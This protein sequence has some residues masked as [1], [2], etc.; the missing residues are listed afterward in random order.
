MA[1]ASL[2]D[3]SQVRARKPA[4]RVFIS[5]PGDVAEERVVVGQVL[6]RL[7][8]EF[9]DRGAVEPVDWEHEPLLATAS[10]QEQIPLPS[11]C[12]V[13]VSILWTRLGT[14]L[15][16][17]IHRPDGSCYASGTEFEFE[18]AAAAFRR[19]AKPDLLV[20]R[21][22]ADPQVSLGDEQAL[23]A[24]LRQKRA[25]D[26]FFERWFVGKD[27]VTLEA[28]FHPFAHAAELEALAET[29]LRKVLDRL[30]PAPAQA[31]EVAQPI[32]WRAGSPFRGL[33]VFELK[34]A[35]IFFGRRWEIVEVLGALRQQ[36][37]MGRAF[38][39][40]LG[41]TG[42]GKSS[43]VRAGVLPMLLQPGVI[44]GIGL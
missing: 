21:K 27:G 39:L 14:R 38:V 19:T 25:L 29:H 22:T 33:E 4:L 31:A 12:D 10:F 3:S 35:A 16:A 8:S 13:V 34:H 23:L 1:V 36:A 44:E 26:E 5:S 24:R 6:R 43:L 28:A 20:Y 7:Q 11:Q 30:L 2:S 18:D 17:R 15:P 32:Q 37:T 9:E 42:C 41:M 40:I